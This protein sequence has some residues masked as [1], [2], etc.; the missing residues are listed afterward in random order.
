MAPLVAGGGCRRAQ[1]LLCYPAS[2]RNQEGLDELYQ[3]SLGLLNFT[4]VPQDVFGRQLAFNIW[5]LAD[6]A[7]M[8][9]RVRRETMR[10]LRL[11]AG[12]L[13]V[14]ALQVPVFHGHA[15]AL[16][17]EAP[18][19]FPAGAMIEALEGAGGLTLQEPDEPATPV[20]LAGEGGVVVQL[21]WGDGTGRNGWWL[22][23]VADDLAAGAADNAVRVAAACREG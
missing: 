5:P 6:A 20:G 18:G 17:L 13:T 10:I 12:R 8:A 4:P 1:A 11:T 21:P 3:Q 14:A 22:W 9:E 15:V 19:S 23:A 7:E 16:H 2:E